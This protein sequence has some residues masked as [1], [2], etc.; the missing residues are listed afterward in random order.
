MSFVWHSSFEFGKINFDL[1]HY[2]RTLFA[3][4]RGTKCR[5]NLSGSA[6]ISDHHSPSHCE[7]QRDVAISKPSSRGPFGRADEKKASFL[8]VSICIAN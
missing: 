8:L 6:Q 1:A 2:V 4:L 5:G 3:S 7:E